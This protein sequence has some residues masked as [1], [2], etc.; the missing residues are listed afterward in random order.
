M[1]E[2]LNVSVICAREGA[3]VSVAFG[4]FFVLGEER[5]GGKEGR[6][7][8]WEIWYENGV[9]GGWNSTLIEKYRHLSKWR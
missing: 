2:H 3:D 7:M 8:N 1:V 4:C 5:E 9:K 6:E